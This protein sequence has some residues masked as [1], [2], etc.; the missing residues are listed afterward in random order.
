[1]SFED[2]EDW[3][4][5]NYVLP[6]PVRP[7]A[8]ELI[9][10]DV[11]RA[12]RVLREFISELTA[13]HMMAVGGNRNAYFNLRAKHKDYSNFLTDR[14]GQSYFVPR[15]IETGIEVSVTES[16]RFYKFLNAYNSSSFVNLE[17]VGVPGDWL[18]KSYW[19]DATSRLI[20]LQLVKV[21]L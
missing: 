19:G 11:A 10:K 3:E 15:H 6:E 1:M 2:F 17:H 5:C 21:V 9:E 16:E 20:H 13:K 12:K 8:S 7:T 18:I 14:Y 4:D